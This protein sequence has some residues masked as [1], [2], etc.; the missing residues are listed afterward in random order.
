MNP[1]RGEN[2]FLELKLEQAVASSCFTWPQGLPSFH[3]IYCSEICKIILFVITPLLRTSFGPKRVLHGLVFQ[4]I[5]FASLCMKNDIRVLRFVSVAREAN[6]AGRWSSGKKV[7]FAQGSSQ[8]KGHLVGTAW[9][10]YILSLS[11][12]QQRKRRK[13]LSTHWRSVS[14]YWW[15]IDWQISLIYELSDPPKW[16]W[17]S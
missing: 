4:R 9:V 3:V 5:L 10:A 14:E 16:A 8:L 13:M 2:L 15:N 7:K 12:R 1:F 11:I 17:R 6:S